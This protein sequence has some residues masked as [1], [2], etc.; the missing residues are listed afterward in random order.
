[1]VKIEKKGRRKKGKS[2]ASKGTRRRQGIW[3]KGF[4]EFGFDLC[5]LADS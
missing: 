4:F 3:E 5:F 2:V 1:M